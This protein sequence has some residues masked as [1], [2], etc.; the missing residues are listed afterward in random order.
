MLR[1]VRVPTVII[2]ATVGCATFFYMLFIGDSPSVRRA[3]LMVLCG[4]A[5]FFFDRDKDYIN[6]LAL[7]CVILWVLNP[8][9]IFSPGFLLSF[10][11]T[12]GILF[13]FPSLKGLLRRSAAVR[14][15]AIDYLLSLAFVSLS[16]QLYI[17][18]V[19]LSFFGHFPYINILANIP[20]VPLAGLS[21][22]LEICCLL[23]YPVFMPLAVLVAESNLVVITLILRIASLCAAV[24]PLAVDGFPPAV[25]PFYWTGLTLLL[26][27]LFRRYEKKQEQDP[28]A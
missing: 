19:M 15:K 26:F 16:V 7:T 21:L 14:F 13:L 4:T 3:S 8:L 11:A 27:L 1:S 28:A 25:I 18:P 24:P 5:L 6:M 2:Y 12:F 17:L 10:S 23:L 22:A 20:I 9:V